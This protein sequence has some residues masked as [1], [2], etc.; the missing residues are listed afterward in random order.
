MR[1][2]RSQASAV[3][4]RLAKPRTMRQSSEIATPTSRAKT[5]VAHAAQ[6]RRPRHPSRDRR[7]DVAWPQGTRPVFNPTT[8][9]ACLQ[10][11]MAARS[12][13]N[14]APRKR[15]TNAKRLR[16]RLAAGAGPAQNS[17]PPR[18][19]TIA[20]RHRQVAVGRRTELNPS[21][22][23]VIQVPRFAAETRLESG[24]RARMA[25]ACGDEPKHRPH[26][27]SEMPLSQVG[28]M[29]DSSPSSF[30]DC[31]HSGMPLQ[32]EPM[33]PCCVETML[34]TNLNGMC[35]IHIDRVC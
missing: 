14:A 9:A 16:R 10:P 5:S 24:R 7:R 33:C 23:A 18:G 27:S 3:A 20:P 8:P 19:T 1:R 28:T 11:R 29:R 17:S 31:R 22:D 13:T 12:I 25:V 2:P 6:V 26:A 4:T 30:T 32:K 35:T 21:T 15:W 34:K